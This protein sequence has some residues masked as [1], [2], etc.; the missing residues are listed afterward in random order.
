MYS[1]K[2]IWPGDNGFKMR[3]AGMLLLLLLFYVPSA[4][5]QTD[6]LPEVSVTGNIDLM[7]RYIWRGQEYGQS[8]SIQPSLS[9]TWKNITLGSWGAYK[10]TGAGDQETDF[11][12]SADFGP[13]NIAVWDY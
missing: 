13:L 8:P 7:S 2:S 4:F 10:L 9:A 1:F 12:L 5:S 11:S 6:S 3:I